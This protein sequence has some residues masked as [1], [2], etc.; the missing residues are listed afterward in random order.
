M[1]I[2]I[3]T[4]HRANNYGAVLQCYA[5]SHYLLSLGHLVEVIDYNPRVFRE[6]YSHF[7][8]SLF[9]KAS[10][11]GSIHI[12]VF[13][14]LNY[15]Y[16]KKRN[17]VFSEFLRKHLCLS[18]KQYDESNHRIHG[19]DLVFFGSDQIWN[20][21]LTGGFDDVFT[22]NFEKG[23]M[24]FVS[25]AASTMLSDK[26]FSD[27]RLSMEYQRILHRF[28]SV[29]VRENTFAEYLNSLDIKKVEVVLDPVFLLTENQWSSLS[30][31]KQEESFL[32]LYAV[33][34][35]PKITEK[36]KRIAKSKQLAF[37]EIAANGRL[38]IN[39][40]FKRILDPESFVSLFRDASFIVTSSFHGTSFS[41]IF[42]KPFVLLLK[43]NSYDGRAYGLMKELHLTDRAVS[44]DEDL[45]PSERVDYER[46]YAYLSEFKRESEGFI[47]KALEHI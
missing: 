10:F 46:A 43:G 8:R 22:G 1:R 5:L 21:S 18:E 17:I 37:V 4:F 19:Y 14:L 47:S 44:L 35:N 13:Y 40:R 23:E 28:D 33:P 31:R 16:T 9:K 24:K 29:S 42:R 38:Y 25:Y 32:L 15:P 26:D 30:C 20:P 7:P 3:L 6:E 36:A 11:L 41:V 27:I 45:I 12:L 34:S 2:G 39:G